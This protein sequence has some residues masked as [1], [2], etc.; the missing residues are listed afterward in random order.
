VFKCTTA[1]GSPQQDRSRIGLIFVDEKSDASARDGQRRQC[2]EF[3]RDANFK[4]EATKKFSRDV[5]LLSLFPH[6][7]MRGK[8]FRYELIS[9]EGDE[10]RE[11]LLDVPQYDFNWQNS[12]IFSE[13]RLIPAGSVLHCTA[14]FD[15]SADNLSNPDPNKSVRWGQQTWEE[16][17]IG[18]YDIGL[19]I[20]DAEA[21]REKEKRSPAP[22]MEDRIIGTE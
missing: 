19:P 8:S 17:M 13:P 15:N 18:W 10:K 7:H 22:R 3:R 12:F 21:L 5:T 14:Y 16:M 11:I 6:M 9:P 20:H 4:V 2:R 1:I